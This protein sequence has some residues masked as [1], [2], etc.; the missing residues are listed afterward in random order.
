MKS[1]V[2]AGGELRDS[3]KSFYDELNKFSS[4]INQSAFSLLGHNSLIEVGWSDCFRVFIESF[5]DSESAIKNL[6]LASLHKLNSINPNVIELYIR[7]L[8][9]EEHL[10]GQGERFRVSSKRVI[11]DLVKNHTDNFIQDNIHHLIQSVELAGSL[12]T[13]S[14][15]VSDSTR[16]P[17]LILEEGFRSDCVLDEFFLP[18]LDSFEMSNCKI[19]M[20]DG[21]VIEVSEIHHILQSSYETKQPFLLITTG[22]SEDVSNTLL[23]NWEQGKTKI[24]PFQINDRVESVNEI[25]DISVISGT[26]ACSDLNGLR[27]SSVDIENIPELVVRYSSEKG[28]LSIIPDESSS[29]R[30]SRLRKQIRKKIN[31][32]NVDDVKDILS[33]RMSKLCLRNVTLELPGTSSV[34]G[35]IKDKTGSFFSHI[36]G[37][38]GQGVVDARRIFYSDY[39]LQLLP[40]LDADIAIKRAVSD[41]DA[42]HNI[43]AIVKLEST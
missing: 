29:E 26:E 39:H 43:R 1:K 40:Y 6:V 30:I 38:A 20:V 17:L 18:Y 31:D 10:R 41:R 16:E 8:A 22:L 34:S 24:I 32:S 23:V 21:K 15:E 5:K 2:I 27:I 11:K 4:S 7:T 25:K 37:C 33:K 13:V 42:I 35:I 28:I 14:V 12:G 36:S 9:G 19:V 3:Q